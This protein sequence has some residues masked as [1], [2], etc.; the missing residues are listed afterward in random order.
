MVSLMK[1]WLPESLW[2]FF[3]SRSNVF[4]RSVFFRARATNKKRQGTTN[5]KPWNSFFY[6]C[7]WLGSAI[8]SKAT[9][10]ARLP[11]HIFSGYRDDTFLK[12]LIAYLPQVLAA[13]TFKGRWFREHSQ[14]ISL[15][16]SWF[17]KNKTGGRGRSALLLE[18]IIVMNHHN[19]SSIWI[20]T[21]C[22]KWVS[23]REYSVMQRASFIEN[24][25]VWL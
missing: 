2:I 16:W 19:E 12:I 20:L 24:F 3:H 21:R 4:N 10:C 8:G 23:I 13:C 7:W 1:I 15:W 25:R 14:W 5:R 11:L 18:G 17:E 9:L 6:F 22:I